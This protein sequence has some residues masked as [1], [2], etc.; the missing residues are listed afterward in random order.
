[1]NGRPDGRGKSSSVSDRYRGKMDGDIDNQRWAYV[2]GEK[3]DKMQRAAREFCRW[4][5]SPF[6]CFKRR[7]RSHSTKQ[8]RRR[9]SN[10]K[11]GVYSVT[12]VDRESV[13]SSSFVYC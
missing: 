7:V 3:E 5:R 4:Y 9:G 6:V 12:H 13:V 10:Y 8:L 1:M 2:N 11:L